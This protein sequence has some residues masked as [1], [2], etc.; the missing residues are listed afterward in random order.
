[1]IQEYALKSR[2]DGW[3]ELSPARKKDLIE[4]ARYN[5]YADR[6]RSALSLLLPFLL[7]LSAGLL[8]V[9]LVVIN[10]YFFEASMGLYFGGLLLILIALAEGVALARTMPLIDEIR[11]C[12]AAQR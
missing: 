11:K 10:Q 3:S 8:I 4:Q 2:I 12:L 9:A 6:K 7:L 5:F 1:M